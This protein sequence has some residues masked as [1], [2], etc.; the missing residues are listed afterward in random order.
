[1]HATIVITKPPLYKGRKQIWSFTL[2]YF[3][4]KTTIESDS[5]RTCVRLCYTADF[6]YK[7]HKESAVCHLLFKFKSRLMQQLEMLREM[8]Y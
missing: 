4:S 2:G 5:H 8:Q 1:M 3:K 7:K 6:I